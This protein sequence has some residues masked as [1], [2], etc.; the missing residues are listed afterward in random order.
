M[1]RGRKKVSIENKDFDKLI[2]E[3]NEKIEESKRKINEEKT[4]ISEQKKI[5]KSL[6]KEKIAYEEYKKKVDEEARLKELLETIKN[7]GK[8]IEEIEAFVK[9]D[10]KESDK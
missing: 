1:P 6:E 9:S 7:S 2:A 3:A 8:T 4:S 10:K 5:V